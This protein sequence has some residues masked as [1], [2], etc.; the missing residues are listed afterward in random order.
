MLKQVQH[1]TGGVANGFNRDLF[2]VP[3][4]PYE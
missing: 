2:S 3:L 4:N 1:D